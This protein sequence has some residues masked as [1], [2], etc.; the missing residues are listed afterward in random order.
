[1]Q[2]DPDLNV[3][4]C[5]ICDGFHLGHRKITGVRNV[6]RSMRFKSL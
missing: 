3:Y 5:D 1:M 4:E 2:R 6:E